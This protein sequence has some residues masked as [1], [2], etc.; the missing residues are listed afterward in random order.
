MGCWTCDSGI[1]GKGPGWRPTFGTHQ[2]IDGIQCQKKEREREMRMKVLGLIW[3]MLI[4]PYNKPSQISQMVQKDMV[5]NQKNSIK[6][7]KP[8]SLPVLKKKVS[9]QCS[10][11]HCFLS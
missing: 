9:Q 1:Q 7:I 8:T 2:H 11:L 6:N 4:L 3:R 5:S 10:S